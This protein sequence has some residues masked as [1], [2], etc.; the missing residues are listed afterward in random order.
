MHMVQILR[1]MT[2]RMHQLLIM[3]YWNELAKGWFVC[4]IHTC[5]VLI[6]V[7]DAIIYFS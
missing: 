6:S 7:F 4:I 5:L 2:L 3:N 1:C